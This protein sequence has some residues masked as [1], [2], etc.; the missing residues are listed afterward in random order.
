[1]QDTFEFDFISTKENILEFIGLKPD[2]PV[3][4]RINNKN[5][6]NE[7]TDTWKYFAQTL[8]ININ[9]QRRNRLLFE[10]DTLRLSMCA[11]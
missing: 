6:T 3:Y 4:F 1:M 11:F 10:I 7:V 2:K 9:D 8:G 5:M